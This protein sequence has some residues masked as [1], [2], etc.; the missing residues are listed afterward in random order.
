MKKYILWDFDC[1][2]AYRDG[3]W[4]KTMNDIL[5]SHRINIA[6]DSLRAFMGRGLPWHEFERP[7]TELLGNKTWWEHVESYLE[8][9]FVILGVREV[10]AKA[11]AKE[12]KDRYLDLSQWH[13]YE[14]T[15]ETLEKLSEEGYTHIIASNHVPEL[16]QLCEQLNLD[17]YFEKIYS[18]A[19]ME[20]DKPNVKFY[21]EILN[22]LNNPEDIVM[23]GDNYNADIRGAKHAGITAILVRSENTLH[24]EHYSKDLKG[25]A[26]LLEKIK[27][28]KISA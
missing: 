3:K 9:V 8:S 5:V 4:S 10:H 19:L 25:V 1:T 11:Y 15:V 16:K 27:N 12:F 7:H 20:Y 2:L 24:Y 22:D 6:Y 14:D 26:D 21:Q 13:V 17:Q 23:I 28:A 18:S